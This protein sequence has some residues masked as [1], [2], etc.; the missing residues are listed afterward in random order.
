MKQR[1]LGKTGLS[2]SEISFGAWALGGGWG[3]QHDADSSAALH[4][5]ID[6]GV[7]FIDTAAGTATAAASASSLAC[8]RSAVSA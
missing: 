7:T 6:R 1:P 5:A 8:S 2:V 3:A 4:E